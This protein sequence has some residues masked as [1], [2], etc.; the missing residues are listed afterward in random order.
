MIE[1]TFEKYVLTEVIH[2]NT[3]IRNYTHT[4]HCDM[5]VT[6]SCY[7]RSIHNGTLSDRF[8]WQY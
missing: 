4:K 3:A 5:Q 7:G 2:L 8:L 1:N 6:Y